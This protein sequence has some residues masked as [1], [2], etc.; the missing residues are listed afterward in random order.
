MKKVILIFLCAFFV[1][2]YFVKEN[3]TKVMAAPKVEAKGAVLIDEKT[4]RV[5]WEKNAYD[6]MAMASTTKIMTLIVALE[7]GNMQ[8]KVKISSKA[9]RQPKVKMNLD[10]D[11]EI[12]LEYLLYALMLQSFND[13]AVAIAEHIGG[14][15]ETF[16]Q[17]M[18]D[19]A[20]EIGAYNTCFETPSGLD[21]DKHYS[22]PY[23]MAL[24][25]K[26]A[27]DNEEFIRITN[28]PNIEVHSNKANYSLVNKNRLL[29]QVSG[30]KGVKTGFT[31][32]AG[33][34]FVGAVERDE[35]SIISVVLGSGWGHDREQK[36]IDT[37][38]ILSYGFD[39][40]KYV[41]IIEAGQ[42]GGAP[43]SVHRAKVGELELMFEEG[44]MLPL[45][46]EEQAGLEV[47]VV[48][49]SQINAPVKKGDKI[50]VGKVYIGNKLEEEIALVSK[51]DIDRHD[52]KTSVEKVLNQ[53]FGLIGESDVVLPEVW[54][55]FLVK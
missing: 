12:K 52:L 51:M 46:E 8:D 10:V 55:E 27:L 26:Y 30:A 54:F 47:K 39:N 50:G 28:T 6:Q 31:N 53:W 49:P 20:K 5:L 17:M 40:F 15:V 1:K 37:K 7:N 24:I 48:R 36:W 2:G 45:S 9:A 4:G 22:T 35:L 25:A 34:C 11:E 14:D 43:V 42:D 38:E 21:G 3:T 19:K 32:K 44:L 33:H 29:R 13:S 23:D 41:D 18:T 16:C